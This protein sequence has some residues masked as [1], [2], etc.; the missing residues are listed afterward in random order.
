MASTPLDKHHY[1]YYDCEYDYDYD[2]NDDYDCDY[3]TL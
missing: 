2:Y 3:G 1:D